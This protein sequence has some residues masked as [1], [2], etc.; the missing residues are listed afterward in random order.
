[1]T[2]AN[3]FT[4]AVEQLRTVWLH[5][6]TMASSSASPQRGPPKASRAV[7]KASQVVT[8]Y[9]RKGTEDDVLRALI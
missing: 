4:H 8:P 5:L 7:P 2:D 3:G 6:T 9:K 1:M